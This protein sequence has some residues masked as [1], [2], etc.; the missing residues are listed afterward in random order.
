[1]TL[2]LETV[3]KQLTDSGIV[4]P[5][6]IEQHVP[7]KGNWTTGEE[8][9]AELVKTGKL[10]M[11]QAA[12][13]KAG[14]A[15]ALTLGEYTLLAKIGAGGMGQVFKA[16]HRRMDRTV[17][18]KMLP[19]TMTKDEEAIARFG[20]EVRAAAK[21]RHPNIVAAD[22]AGHANGVHFLVMEHVDG[23]DLYVVVKMNGPLPVATA[24]N[25]V[26]Q[27]ARG[28]EF[29]HKKGVVHRD[30]K[31]ANLLLDAEGTVKILDMGLA[32]LE[33]SGE[34]ATEANLTVSGAVMGTVDY[35]A[36]EQALNTKTA[37]ARADI[38]SLGI[39]LYYLL[40][41]KAAYGGDSLMEKLLAHREQ[42]IP[43]L[44][45][46]HTAIP[47]RLEEIF[48]KMVAKS[49]DERY[50]SMSEVI[51]AL[52]SLGYGESASANRGNSATTCGLIDADKQKLAG[53]ALKNL[54]SPIA[55]VAANRNLATKI[56]GLVF[57]AIIG[58]I[59]VKY[60]VA[61]VNRGA[62]STREAVNAPTEQASTPG[63]P[64]NKASQAAAALDSKPGTGE[65]DDLTKQSPVAAPATAKAPF[66]AQ[67]AKA[68]QAAWAKHLELPVESINSVG[69]KMMLIPPGEFLMGSTDEQVEA[70]LTHA[71]EMNVDQLAKD[72]IRKSERPQ[73]RVRITKPFWLGA[74]EVTVGQF[75]KFAAAT[76]YQTESQKAAN[77]SKAKTYKNP[78]YA[79]A[80]DSP[81]AFITWNDAVAFCTWLSRQEKAT[82]RLPTEAEWEYACRAGTTTQYP[83]G[84]DH[85][86]LA[87][88]G[89]FN[90]N[91]G[92]RSHAVGTLSPNAF[93]LFDMQ[94]NVQEWCEDRFEESW[95]EKS[96]IDDPTGPAAGSNRVMRGGPWNHFDSSC[97]SA[98]RFYGPPT[99]RTAYNP[100]FRVVR[101]I[102]SSQA[103]LAKLRRQTTLPDS[104]P[105]IKILRTLF[106]SSEKI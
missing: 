28:L 81:A 74:T 44:Q 52:E 13:V 79:V 65:K 89:W 63:G 1:M 20:R 88:Y 38:Y 9:L 41:G 70:A 82:Y 35:M 83:F 57:A 91:A 15:R 14:K 58:L 104:V 21:L 72:R 16:V 98:A 11:F 97:R 48:R 12:Q 96:P 4:S 73:H 64:S 100:G 76:G 60:I 33:C 36:P 93:G 5:S 62:E 10:T 42:P 37:D 49:V 45:S 32:R 34:V 2:A 103:A 29:A 40:A 59:A 7:P 26:W 99:F 86:E 50:Q 84:D 66:N 8:L 6:T 61:H 106:G 87:K 47:K 43:S 105:G 69:M 68:Y 18:I 56:V 85:A 92:G 25:Y 46:L 23:S 102:D 67:Q 19:P 53:R 80:D 77:E 3:I 27:A 90:K 17:A 24:A 101:V 95:Y 30:I 78:G 31:P 39:T 22:D 55:V 94:G 51:E 75:N 54:P 71:E